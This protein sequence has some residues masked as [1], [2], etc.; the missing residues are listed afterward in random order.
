M[1]IRAEVYRGKVTVPDSLFSLSCA[2]GCLS[3]SCLHLSPLSIRAL[4]CST[5]KRP[6]VRSHLGEAERDEDGH[7]QQVGQVGLV[8]SP[9]V[10]LRT[11]WIST[12]LLRI[13]TPPGPLCTGLRLTIPKRM[14]VATPITSSRMCDAATYRQCRRRHVLHHLIIL[15]ALTTSPPLLSAPLRSSPLLSAPL[16]S[17]PIIQNFGF[18]CR[19]R[20]CLD[21]YAF[22][23]DKKRRKRCPRGHPSSHLS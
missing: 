22:P 6:S 9:H 10:L 19:G 17:S 12:L 23:Q 16:R 5:R 8:R 14:A 4:L 15:F 20:A 21:T 13:V 18:F 11:G 1:V 2:F 7:Q 3:Y